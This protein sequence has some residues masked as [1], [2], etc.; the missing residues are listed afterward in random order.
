MRKILAWFLYIFS[1]TLVLGCNNNN[2]K[3]TY[4][5]T[6]EEIVDEKFV[7]NWLRSN[8]DADQTE[9]Q[10]FFQQGMLELQREAW[11]PAVKSF[12]TSMRL[13]PS[14]E[15]LQK[16][17]D[18]NLKMLTLV[19]KRDGDIEEKLPLDM[20]NALKLY[21]SAISANMVSG[22]LTEEEKTAIQSNI[23][24]LETYAASGRSDL[25]CQPL[26]WYQDAAR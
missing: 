13:Y 19:R 25:D 4:F 16:Y 15:A 14:P 18:V 8:K 2:E 21:R 24:C 20:N 26:R 9:A 1:I 6:S 12:G 17:V 11:S 3:E 7:S 10:I 5:L 23:H 22:T